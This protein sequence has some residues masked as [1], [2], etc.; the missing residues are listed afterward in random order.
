[1]QEDIYNLSTPH[2]II[3]RDV[4]ENNIRDMALF[5]QSAGVSLRPHIKSHKIPEIARLQ[6]EFGA[7]GITVSKIGEAE[8]M[9]DSGIDDI[10]IAY[11]I[12]GK[13]KIQRLIDL[14]KRVNVRV[15]VDS[16]YGLDILNEAF[17]NQGFAI[18]VMIEIDT[19]LKR[20]GLEPGKGVI[21][22]AKEVLKRRA[23]NFKGIFTHAG[24]AYGAQNRDQVRQIGE[25][26]GRVMARLADELNRHG[27]NVEVVSVGSTPTAKIS[28]KEKRV[29][30]IRPGNYVFYDAIQMGLGTADENMC[31][32]RVLT[33]VISKP[34]PDR[35]IIDAGSK[36]F[37]LDK[38][39][40]G[41]SNVKGFGYIVGK[42]GVVIERLSEEHGILD[43]SQN[44]DIQIGEMLEVIPNHACPVINLF[45]EVAY[46]EG[47][48]VK[49]FWKIA[50]RGK[51]R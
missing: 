17:E 39:A 5:A 18:D 27:I 38:G 31:S 24:N 10:F 48:R 28:G 41:V 32:L 26:E 46:V 36:T 37:A 23:L 35:A 13:D 1:M 14:A 3:R 12:I 30:E 16:L 45:D 21:D 47:S 4:L 25:E 34:S 22:F 50:A 29:T 9:A 20:C 51:N 33:T 44:H 49:G 43:I 8:V 40:H 42:K 2:L 7:K 11:Q 19:G 6:I 15:G